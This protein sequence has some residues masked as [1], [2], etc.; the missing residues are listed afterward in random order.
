MK[1][2][3]PFALFHWSIKKALT[4]FSN[5]LSTRQTSV[6]KINGYA[7]PWPEMHRISYQGMFPT[8]NVSKSRRIDQAHCG[9][10]VLRSCLHV[11]FTWFQVSGNLATR[12]LKKVCAT[13]IMLSVSTLVLRSDLVLFFPWLVSSYL[14]ISC[15]TRN[16]DDWCKE[17]IGRAYSAPTRYRWSKLREIYLKCAKPIDH[18]PDITWPDNNE[19]HHK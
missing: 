9:T 6:K 4:D 8:G 12:S 19:K 16:T 2:L 13:S 18:W 15:W 5:E 14:N 7:P 17:Y 1:K 3:K 11:A 10:F